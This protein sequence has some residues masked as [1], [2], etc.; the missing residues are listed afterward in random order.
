MSTL[1]TSAPQQLC[2]SILAS[3]FLQLVPSSRSSM[4]LPNMD[5]LAT[6]PVNSFGPLPLLSLQAA[7][8]RDLPLCFKSPSSFEGKPLV[9]LNISEASHTHKT[10]HLT[11]S[12]ISRYLNL[13]MVLQSLDSIKSSHSGLCTDSRLP[14]RVLAC[15]ALELGSHRMA[16]CLP[17]LYLPLFCDHRGE[18]ALAE[19]TEVKT[20]T[21]K[22][23]DKDPWRKG[24]LLPQTSDGWMWQI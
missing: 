15:E 9:L 4:S 13:L 22:L 12:Y 17:M 11:F 20:V 21:I 1:L 7:P 8:P 2:C 19:Y 24:R 23:D 16:K 5:A 10:W 6:Y 18:Y 3:L 14:N